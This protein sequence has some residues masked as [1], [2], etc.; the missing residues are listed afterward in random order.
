MSNV[1]IKTKIRSG[2]KS[3][4]RLKKYSRKNVLIVCDK[5]MVDSGAISS[6]LMNIKDSNTVEIFDEVVP[7]P[8]VEVVGKG[9]NA[10]C[11][12]MP[13]IIIGFGG[14]SAIDTAKGIIYF[15][16]AKN[17]FT[18]PVFITIPTTSGTGS[19]V[20]SATVIRDT[21]TQS[22]HLIEDELIL[23]DVALLDSELTLSVPPS[24]TANTGMDVMTHA[25]EAYVAAGA[26]V[27][28]DA[29][30]EK[31]VELSL[32]ALIEC[33][34]HGSNLEARTKMQEASTLAGMS[35]DTA[36]L[37]VNHAMAH[38]LGGTFHIPHGLANALL[39]ES[40]IAYNSQNI[41]VLE[42]Y[43][44]MAYKTKMV[45][46]QESPQLAV[47]VLQQVL[48]TMKECMKLPKK[49]RELDIDEKTYMDAVDH[50]AE[51][52]LRDHCVLTNPRKTNIANLKELFIQLY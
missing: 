34:R 50:M 48:S 2:A 35:F 40:V 30:A 20:T 29:L 47:K 28:S 26:N 21:E 32:E 5:F 14:G 44:N 9:L 38:Q 4:E 13:D 15:A 46:A 11:R 31:A 43:A 8:T 7:D 10:A 12:I 16:V 39:L 25:L 52:A 36:G 49:I 42:K 17:L 23:A 24:I 1:Y 18:K 33:Y 27:F 19:E 37:G 3:L 51:N 6:I 41:D 45:S 22:K